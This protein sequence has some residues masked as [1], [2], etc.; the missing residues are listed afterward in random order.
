MTQG[1]SHVSVCAG[2]MPAGLVL[3]IHDLKPGLAQ[4][5]SMRVHSEVNG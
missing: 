1:V 4:F 3:C 2:N 5:K